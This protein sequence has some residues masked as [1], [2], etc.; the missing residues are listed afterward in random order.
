MWIDGQLTTLFEQHLSENSERANATTKSNDVFIA[1]DIRPFSI[2][3]N[4][5]FKHM[6]K[7]NIL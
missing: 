4:T 7:V 1:A 3:E 6:M 2:V 5:G